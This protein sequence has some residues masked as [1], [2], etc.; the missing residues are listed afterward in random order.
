MVK[1]V[2]RDQFANIYLQNGFLEPVG[3]V[4]DD[5]VMRRLREV[6]ADWHVGCGRVVQ[7]G[8]QVADVVSRCVADRTTLL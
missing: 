5:V 6:G 4:M 3:Y 1:I 2:V 7:R 8:V